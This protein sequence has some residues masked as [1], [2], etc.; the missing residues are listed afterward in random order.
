MNE[1]STGPGIALGQLPNHS[2]NGNAASAHR[3]ISEGGELKGGDFEGRDL[4]GVDLRGCDLAGANL[5]GANLFKANL[6]GAHLANAC[7]ENADLTGADL[8]E[9]NLDSASL[10]N[11]GLGMCNLT[12]AKLFHAN[13]ENCTLSKANLTGAD[14]RCANL[15]KARLREAVLRKTD[16]TSADLRETDLTECRVGE[17]IFNKADLRQSSTRSIREFEKAKWTGV[18]IRDVNFSGSYLLCRFIIDENFIDEFRL[19]SRFNSWVYYLWWDTSD[20][21][22][23]MTRWCCWIAFVT[24]LFAGCYRLAD[25]NYAHHD[26]SWLSTIY[27]SVVTLTTLG[28]GDIQPASTGAQVIAMIKVASGYVLLGGLL[29]IFA[30]K[31]ARRGD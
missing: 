27:Y 25:L 9:A 24:L 4:I 17:A 18:D 5:K 11:A 6:S 13:L 31:M 10:G 2:G 14:L 28:Y 29:S 20:C 3:L 23:S 30:N 15:Q 16:F 1:P 21:G 19:S 7:L 8:T 22:R 12:E 26:S